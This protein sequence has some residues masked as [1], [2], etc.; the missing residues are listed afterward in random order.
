[1]APNQKNQ[2]G[3]Y[4]GWDTYHSLS[5]LQAML[6]PDAAGDMAQSQVNYYSEDKILQQ[7]G[8]DNLNNYVMVGD[9]ADALIADYYAFGAHNFNTKQALSDM[10]A[11]ADS[12]NDV[13]PGEALEAEYGFLPE[14]GTYGC[15]RAHGF[16]SAL[17]EYDTADFALA[18]FAADMGDTA[19]SARLTRRANNWENLFDPATDLLTSRLE[20]GLFEASVTPTFDGVFPT[21]HE[22]YVEGDPYEYLWDV[23]NDYS[24][25]FSL[26][27]GDYTVQSLLTRYLSRP[28]G[29]GMY[30]VLTNEFDLGE[31]FALDYAGDPAGTQQAVANIRNTIYRPGPSGL[32]NND[33]LGAISSTFVWE[34]LG[35]Y[36]ENPGHGT[37]AFASP[38]FPHEKIH[39]GNGRWVHINAPGASPS[40]YYAQ[41]LTVNGQPHPSPWIN[42]SRIAGGVTLDWTLANEPTAWGSA[43]WAAP[44][45][46]GEGLRPIVGYVTQQHVTIAPGA[47]AEI[48][49]GAQNATSHPERAQFH[50]KLPAAS[51][52]S[53][54]PA[55]GTLPIAADGRLTLP[56]TV[57]AASSAISRFDWVTVTVTGAG[58]APQTVELAVQIT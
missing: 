49:L 1:L 32:N 4:S 6:D 57:R 36:P 38:G 3:M 48:E 46:D 35:M 45:S 21:D 51:G 14:D 41:S 22:P 37:L 54:S 12:V 53:V 30:A 39:L 55:D 42:Y 58:G 19:D 31:P 5:Q 24:A 50:I 20:N 7:W 18:Q 34:M 10:L 15:C 23:P 8:Y 40:V 16:T 47:S 29:Y 43:P 9:P 11:Q 52:L 2:Y 17:L 13:R 56:I 26:L 44:P 25:L 28:N 33:D 27:G